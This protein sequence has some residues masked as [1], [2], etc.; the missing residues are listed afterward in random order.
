MRLS[1]TFWRRFTQTLCF[2]LLVYSG[3]LFIRSGSSGND[4]ESSKTN[5]NISRQS[6]LFTERKPPV[7]DT[8]PPGAICYFVNE[9]GLV[10]GCN[11]YLISDALTRRTSLELVL[12]AVLVFIILSFLA[13][14][15]WCG[16]VCPLGAF[17]DFID[18]LRRRLRIRHTKIP[19]ATKQGL[20][21]SSYML[22]SAT[23]GISFIIGLRQ[24]A[25]L[26]KHL[27]L[28]FCEICPA[29]LI[30]P[31]AA[32]SS[33]GFAG[34]FT[35]SAHCVFTVL[36]YGMLSFF[37]VGFMTARRIWC[38][39]CP[40]GLSNSWFNR[41]GMLELRKEGTRCNRCGVCVDN[42]PMGCMHTR[43]EKTKKVLNHH[44]CIYCLRCIELCPKEK[45]LR[46]N[47]FGL[48][49][50]ESRLRPMKKPLLLR[51]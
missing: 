2:A 23:A 43:D 12:P 21:I 34:G 29:R 10:K 3:F 28:P 8:Y 19:E 7:I 15:L 17:G 4:V 25:W 33:P 26:Q 13:G 37:V 41:G 22:F 16:W 50:V 47:F 45:C 24:F 27:Y 30:C 40:I 42:C 32:G 9:R 46:L 39:F 20:R 44:E 49:I 48:K 6:I 1:I 11:I 38:H 31:V 51:G 35:T 5:G 14:R 18:V 36:M